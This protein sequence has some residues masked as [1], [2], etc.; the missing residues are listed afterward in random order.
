MKKSTVKAIL[1]TAIGV[2]SFMEVV[3]EQEWSISFCLLLII[4]IMFLIVPAF[5]C[6]ESE[7]RKTSSNSETEKNEENTEH[8]EA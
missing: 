3:K 8:T 2:L 7:F 5:M 1:A 6:V 4:S